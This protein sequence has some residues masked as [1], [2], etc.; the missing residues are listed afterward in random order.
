[1][2]PGDELRD[3]DLADSMGELMNIIGGGVKT[4][5]VQNDESLKLGLPLIIDGKIESTGHSEDVIATATVGDVKGQ[6]LIIRTSGAKVA[7]CAV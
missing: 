3:R 5:M 2:E 4:R 1:M 7:E 6:L